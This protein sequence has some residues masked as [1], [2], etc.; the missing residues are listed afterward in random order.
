VLAELAEAVRVGKVD[1]VDL[2]DESL[3]RIDASH[4]TLNAVTALRADEARADAAASPRTGALAGLPLLVKDM[5]RCAGMRTTFGSPLYADAPP[6]TVDDIVVARLRAAG[7][8]VLGRSNTPAFGHTAVTSNRVH[9]TT[10]NPWNPKRSPGGSSGGSAAA[11]IAGLVPLATSSDGGGSVRI[12]ASCCGLVGYKP[13][14]GGIGRNVVPRWISL[15][16][17]GATGRTVADV[18]LE[19]TVTLGPARG[20]ILSLP[21]GGVSVEPR[22]PTRL[23]ACRSFRAD[24]EPVIEAAFEEALTDLAGDGFPVERVTAPFDA[25]VA[26]SWYTIA[27]ADLAQSMTEHRDQWDTF[28]PSLRVQLEAGER[29][30]LFDY[31]AAQ[32]R[33]YELAAQVDD[34]LGADA[35]LVVPTNN[36]VSWPAAGPMPMSAGAIEN[37]LS[38]AINTVDL[39]FTGHPAVSVPLGYDEFGVPFGL[40]IVA[41]RFTEGLALGLAAA[42]ERLRPWPTVAPGYEPYPV[43]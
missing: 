41:P 42:M 5:A 18:V 6:D 1:P 15:S 40:Q 11:L 13:T 35:V 23:L 25:S 8:I 17:Q 4:A 10:R 34:L 29:I 12:P 3:R 39:N 30:A 36:A 31:I 24:V 33:R 32:R 37:D 22:R 16:T 9:G 26:A 20:D 19:A 43:P 21:S 7:A 28:E 38:I 14:M 27:S 2:V